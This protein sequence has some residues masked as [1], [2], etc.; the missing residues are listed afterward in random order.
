MT[1]SEGAGKMVHQYFCRD[2]GHEF[3]RDQIYINEAD[4]ALPWQGMYLI[5]RSC[6]NCH[7]T[8]YAV[9]KG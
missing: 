2:C 8:A 3:K 4:P 9:A 6:Y 1:F 5:C 7:V